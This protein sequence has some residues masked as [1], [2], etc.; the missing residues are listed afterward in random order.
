MPKKQEAKN[1]D[2]TP[3]QAYVGQIVHWKGDPRDEVPSAAIVTKLGVRVLA[4]AVFHPGMVGHLSYDGVRHA[5]DPAIETA[6]N[7][8]AGVWQHLQDDLGWCE[9]EESLRGK[10][11]QQ[12]K[13]LASVA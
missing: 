8:E 5:E 12:G 3:P 4:L 11:E 7:M 1:K 2:F 10:H 13:R 6:G 9:Y